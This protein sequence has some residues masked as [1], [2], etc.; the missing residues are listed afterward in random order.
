MTEL[1]RNNLHSAGD[2]FLQAGLALTF[3]AALATAGPLDAR[4]GLGFVKRAGGL[5]RLGTG[6]LGFGCGGLVGEVL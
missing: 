6:G 2:L 5:N 4:N 1:S 3:S